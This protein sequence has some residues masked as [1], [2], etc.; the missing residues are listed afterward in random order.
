MECSYFQFLVP[1]Q[2][3]TCSF[4]RS[5]VIPPSANTRHL[6]SRSLK[7][8]VFFCMLD[9]LLLVALVP[10]DLLMVVSFLAVAV[11]PVLVLLARGPSVTAFVLSL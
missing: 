6:I 9:G 2:W 8:K 10:V 3:L 5:C 7:L 1:A 4:S 11:V